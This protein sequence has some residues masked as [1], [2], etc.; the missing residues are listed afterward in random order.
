LVADLLVA[1]GY[2][3]VRLAGGPGRRAATATAGRTSAPP[4]GAGSAAGRSQSRCANTPGPGGAR[5]QLDELLG[6]CVRLGCDEGV[7]V[8]TGSFSSPAAEWARELARL[9][10]PPGPAL[11]L[12][13]GTALAELLTAH[14]V[15]VRRGG[16][17]GGEPVPDAAYFA[18]LASPGVRSLQSH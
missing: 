3:D 13:D 14:R 2:S 4:S 7:L 9:E 11:H 6:A 16:G 12:I 15:G 18:G 8:T 10:R 1:L 5:R 17:T